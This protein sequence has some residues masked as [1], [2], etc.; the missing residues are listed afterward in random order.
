MLEENI[1]KTI[2][3]DLLFENEDNFMS[4][5]YYYK[6]ASAHHSCPLL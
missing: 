1:I 2:R 5:N 4:Y 3:N 6:V